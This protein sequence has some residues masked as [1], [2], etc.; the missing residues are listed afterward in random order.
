MF[1]IKTSPTTTNLA[2]AYRNGP[3]DAQYY[4]VLAKWVVKC[5]KSCQNNSRRDRTNDSLIT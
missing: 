1:I 3:I 2:I 5:C 4:Y